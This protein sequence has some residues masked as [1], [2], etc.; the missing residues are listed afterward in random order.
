ML[1]REGE[2]DAG[3]QILFVRLVKRFVCCLGQGGLS[4]GWLVSSGGQC[5]I[6]LFLFFLFDCPLDFFYIVLILCCAIIQAL[7]IYFVLS[8]NNNKFSYHPHN[9]LCVK[10]ISMY[11]QG[12]LVGCDECWEVWWSQ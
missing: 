1:S 5:S 2:G 6:S 10:N 9:L 11:N 7:L 12:S 8:D 4:S 3:T